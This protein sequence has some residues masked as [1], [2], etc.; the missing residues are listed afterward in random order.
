MMFKKGILIIWVV[1]FFLLSLAI[2]IVDKR[3]SSEDTKK[4]YDNIHEAL[5]TQ[6]DYEKTQSL[7]LAIA[8]SNNFLIDEGH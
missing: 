3:L 8:L 1:L 4:A 6:I 2:Y 7:S 5:N